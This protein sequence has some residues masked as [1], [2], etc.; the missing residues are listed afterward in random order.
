MAAVDQ[1][2]AGGV[3]CRLLHPPVWRG[4]CDDAVHGV[5]R[6]AGSLPVLGRDETHMGGQREDLRLRVVVVGV[7][8]PCVSGGA[9]ERRILHAL[10]LADVGGAGAR[11]PRGARA[12]Q[13]GPR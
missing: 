2:D 11:G 4:R 1:G 3:Q 7:R 13:Y 8:V 9:S 10:Q 6:T 12:L 5:S